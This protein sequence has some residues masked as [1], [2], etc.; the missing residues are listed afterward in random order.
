MGQAAP[1]R[2][3]LLKSPSLLLLTKVPR[4]LSKYLGALLCHEVLSM[5]NA[6][7]KINHTTISRANFDL[8]GQED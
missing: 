1:M 4:R 7:G 6:Q 2:L 8:L 5:I 3:G